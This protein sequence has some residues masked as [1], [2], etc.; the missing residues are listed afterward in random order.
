MSSCFKSMHVRMNHKILHKLIKFRCRLIVHTLR[1]QKQ[2]F[3]F[4]NYN[5]VDVHPLKIVPEEFHTN[6]NI[7]KKICVDN[8]ISENCKLIGMFGYIS[9]YKGHLDAIE[10]LA[11]LPKNYVLLIFGRQHPQTIKDSQ[12]MD[13]YL[14]RLKLTI[15]NKENRKL[16]KDRVF[17]MGELTD[18]DFFSV[19]ENVDIVWLPYYEN[20]QDGSGIASICL[21]Q[22]P[23]V[24]CSTSFAFDELFRLIQYNNVVRFD[25]GNSLELATKTKAFLHKTPPSKPYAKESSYSIKQ[26]AMLYVKELQC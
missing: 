24:L 13:D 3:N 5:N 17:F 7:L 6:S 26:Q 23:R 12:R 9:A 16:L 1:A 11:L 25:I 18:E 2:I 10:A 8:S 15:T 21:D 4:C 19:T 20:G 14:E 22:S